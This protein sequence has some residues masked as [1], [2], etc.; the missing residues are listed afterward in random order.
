MTITKEA[1][2]KALSYV[3]DPDLGKDLVTLNMVDNIQIEG[4]KVGFRLI[5]TTPACPL[6]E[7]IKNACITAIKHFVDKE[8]IV[9]VEI[10]SRVTS[11]RQDNHNVLPFVKNI[12]AIASGKGGKEKVAHQDRGDDAQLPRQYE[13]ERPKIGTGQERTT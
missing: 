2:L 6:K 10:T 12:V 11:R 3:D 7:H 4:K 9:E 8:A 13:R 5:L 1:V